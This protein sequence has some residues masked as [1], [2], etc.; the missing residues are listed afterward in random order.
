MK[1][2]IL[3]TISL[4]LAVSAGC[5]LITGQSWWTPVG[6]GFGESFRGLALVCLHLIGIPVSLFL[7][8]AAWEAGE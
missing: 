2:L 4:A 5:W 1:L 6:T 7:S 3:A 8:L